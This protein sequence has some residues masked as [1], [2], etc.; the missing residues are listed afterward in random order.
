[1]EPQQSSDVDSQQ[2]RIGTLAKAIEILEAVILSDQPITAS[3]V[4]TQLNFA[5]PTTH[6]IV[7]HLREFGL[8]SREGGQNPGLVEGERLMRLAIAVLQSAMR[9]GHRHAILEELTRSTGE[10]CCLGVM[11]GGRVLGIDAVESQAQLALRMQVGHPLP[12][13]CTAMGKTHLGLMRDSLRRRYVGTRLLRRYTRNTIADTDRLRTE[14]D[15]VRA[16]G[17]VAIDNQEF[18]NGAV[19]LSVPVLSADGRLIAALALAAPEAR[20]SIE[21][22][23][24]HLPELESAA[25]EI[26]DSLESATL[27]DDAIP[28]ASDGAG[29]VVSL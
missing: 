24:T 15:R 2:E 11:S 7:S 18:I 28:S 25:R 1:M 19:C 13:H 29:T 14:L 26:A 6:R 5:K 21:S 23:E 22:I 20:W 27:D 8:L 16:R 9:R 4:S 3:A 10:S 17:G 12:L